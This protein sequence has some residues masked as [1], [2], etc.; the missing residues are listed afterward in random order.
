MAKQVISKKFDVKSAEQFVYSVRN[1]DG[2]YVF[3]AKHI[4][5]ENGDVVPPTPT[6]SVSNN[7]YNIYDDMLFG[8]RVSNSDVI[9]MIPRYDW[10]ANTVYAMYDDTDS[11]LMSK[12]FYATVNTGAEYHVYKCLYNGGNVASTIEPSGTDNDAFEFANDGYIWKYM[13]S[14][15]AAAMTKF[16]SNTYMPIVANSSVTG[17]A[18]SGSIE[19]IYVEDGGAGYDNYLSNTFAQSSDIKVNGD[20]FNY[21]LAGTASPEDDFYNGCLLFITSGPA[22]NEYREIVDYNG[23]TKVATVNGAFSTSAEPTVGSSYEVNPQV[24]VF[25][26]GGRKQTNCIARA[27]AN[28]AA[29]NSIFKV[30]VI[31]PGSGYRSANAVILVSNQVGV[32]ATAILR[33]ILSPPGG[34]G[35]NVHAELGANYAGVSIQFAQLDGD[36]DATGNGII[37]TDNDYRQVGL[38]KNPLFANV[39]ISFSAGNT[40]G[41]FVPSEPVFKY[42]DTLLSGTVNVTSTSTT[43]TGNGT[44]FEDALQAGDSI[45]IT[46]GATNFFGNVVTISNNTQLTVTSNVGF[47]NTTISISVLDTLPFGQ[48]SANSVGEIYVAN[49]PAQTT[50][51]SSKFIGNDSYATTIADDIQ[52]SRGGSLPDLR[53]NSFNSFTQL[54]KMV[55]TI[56]DGEFIEDEFVFQDSALIFDRPEGRLYAAVEAGPTDYLYLTNIRNVWQTGSSN[57][58]S[59]GS[60][61]EAQ[62]TVSAK[63]DGELIP[64]SGEV[65]YIE[66]ISP[67]SRSNTQ[68]ET[69]RL[70]LEF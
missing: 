23:T 4:P 22:L 40:V 18:V 37:R 6:D 43:V 49:V 38:L 50:M 32:S 55:G 69:I 5:F 15:N 45:L 36:L 67:V 26:T 54:T 47:T 59:T 51:A 13:Y 14:A 62:F 48:I 2:Y 29:A 11:Q 66:N 28:S 52:V 16:A 17:N 8:K 56:D 24:D 3:A 9:Q 20:E 58:I 12:Q 25:D 7:S 44:K 35:A 53:S 21:R 1:L 42:R 19:V 46:D 68:T 64:D 41:T 30:E 63:Y 57:G 65:V 27:I 31:A 33:P 10:T 34:H 70:V 60:T 61:S 39:R